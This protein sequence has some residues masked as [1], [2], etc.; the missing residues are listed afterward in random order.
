MESF[1]QG[2]R[3]S[4]LAATKKPKYRG[5]DTRRQ[6]SGESSFNRSLDAAKIYQLMSSLDGRPNPGSDSFITAPV[7]VS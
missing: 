3:R 6:Q 2:A 5:L 7:Q 1:F 4:F